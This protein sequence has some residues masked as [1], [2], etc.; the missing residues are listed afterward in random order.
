MASIVEEETNK[1]ED[2]GL[3]ASVYI[4]RIQKKMKLEAD[5]TVKYAMRNFGLKRILHGHLQ[6]QSPY[7]TYQYT[8]KV[9]WILS[10]FFQFQ[11]LNIKFQCK[12]IV[13]DFSEGTG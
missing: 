12:G 8:G 3:I 11:F 4:N 10:F 2:K 6:Y 9:P 13:S 7:N 5:P 1:T